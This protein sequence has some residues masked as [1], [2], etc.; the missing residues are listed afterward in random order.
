MKS[1]IFWKAIRYLHLCNLGHD[2]N[3]TLWFTHFG[4]DQCS[5]ALKGYGERSFLGRVIESS[6]HPLYLLDMGSREM[7]RCEI[8][9]IHKLLHLS[10]YLWVRSERAACCEQDLMTSHTG[11][12]CVEM[13]SHPFS[14]ISF[15]TFK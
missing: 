1:T 9:K 15:E 3:Y 2:I 11:C 4:G 10:C 6:L 8:N 14:N 13:S 12:L 5:F 7:R